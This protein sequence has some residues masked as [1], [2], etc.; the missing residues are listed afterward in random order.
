M[1]RNLRLAALLLR[2]AVRRLD[3]L[4]PADRGFLLRLVLLPLRL[5]PAGAQPGTRLA[6]ALEAEGPVFIKF[7]QFLSTRPDLLPPELASALAR[8]RDDCAP[9]KPGQ[10]E[11]VVRTELGADPADIFAHFDPEPIAAASLAQVHGVRLHDGQ[12][13]VVKLLRPGVEQRVERDLQLLKTAAAFAHL[14]LGANWRLPEVVD[15]YSRTVRDECDLTLEAAKTAKMR[16][17]AQK[18][19]LL[20]IPQVHWPLLSRRLLVMER[21]EAIPVTDLKRLEREGVNL[22]LLAERGVRIFFTQL[23]EDNFFHG[24]MHPGNIMVLPDTP[25]TPVYAAVDCA[26][27]G[28]LSEDELILLGRLLQALLGGDFRRVAELMKISG[29]VREDIA[30]ADLEMAIRAGCEPVLEQPLQEINFSDLLLYLFGAARR[31]GLLVQPSLALLVKTLINIEGM[32]RQLYPQLNFW[33]ITR[34]MLD[35]WARRRLS[36]AAIAERAR[37]QMEHLLPQLEQL[38]ELLIASLRQYSQGEATPPPENPDNAVPPTGVKAMIAAVVWSAQFTGM[39]LFGLLL[40]IGGISV[41]RWLGV[42]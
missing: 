19:G 23:F 39:M 24:D 1:L 38:P 8:L 33:D 22:P 28:E 5:I 16:A 31:F 32:G 3:L 21:I 41:L 20:Y 15:L 7:G 35:S 37:R 6:A 2:F 34:E 18:H 36:P 40:T 4:L 27:A 12:E 17:N 9:L 11:Q 42:L 26:I 14:R 13:M 30:A 25:E 29:W 10:A